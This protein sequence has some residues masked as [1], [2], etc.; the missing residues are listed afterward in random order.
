MLEY[1]EIHQFIKRNSKVISLNINYT[2]DTNEYIYVVNVNG[3]NHTLK[4]ILD[5]TDNSVVLEYK[6][7]LIRYSNDIQL[8]LFEIFNYKNIEYIDCY[9][10]KK[11]IINDFDI[12]DMYDDYYDNDNDELISNR[13]IIKDEK[14]IKIKFVCHDNE[15]TMEYNMEKIV[16]FEEI[17]EKLDLIL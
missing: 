13:T 11:K 15:M 6:S 8:E 7:N 4:I 16:G 1:E 5:L 12:I 2:P 9:I 17:I 3:L 14:P 10:F